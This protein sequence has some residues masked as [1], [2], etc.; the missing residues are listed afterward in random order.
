M[1]VK[2]RLSKLESNITSKHGA[3]VITREALEAEV[4]QRSKVLNHL[5]WTGSIN[6]VRQNLVAQKRVLG[7]SFDFD[8]A[9]LGI[10]SD[11]PEYRE[12]ENRFRCAYA[13]LASG[14][15]DK[16]SEILL[17]FGVV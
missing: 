17:R 12:T 3:S 7:R 4:Q 5:G 10:D 2:T 13:E 9:V 14:T 6:D 8:V 16:R 1:S 11:S 15:L